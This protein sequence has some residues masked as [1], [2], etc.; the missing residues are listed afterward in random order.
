LPILVIGVGLRAV[1]VAPAD[2][3]DVRTTIAVTLASS[4]TRV[5]PGHHVT[6]TGSVWPAHAGQRVVLEQLGPSG[7]QPIADAN[8]GRTS[9]FSIEHR[10]TTN[11]TYQLRAYLSSD[12]ANAHSYSP[13]LN[14]AVNGIF[15]IQHVVVVMQENR[16]FDSYFGTYPGA[17]G[18]PGLAGNPGSLPCA[19]DPNNGGC[20]QPFHDTN[21]ENYG[22]P[23]GVANAVPDA[24]CSSYAARTNC[25]MDGFVGQAERARRCTPGEASCLPCTTASTTQCIDAMG[26]HDASEIPN[27]WA[28]ANNFV[29]QDHMFEPNDSYSLPAHLY[30]VSEWSAYCTNPQDPF[31]CTN[32]VQNPNPSNGKLHYAWTDITYLLHKFGVSWGYYVFPGTEPDCA[33]PSAVTCAA[34]TQTPQTPGLWNPLPSFTD[35]THDGQLS[36]I[37]S[38]TNFSTAAQNGTLPNVSWVVPSGQVSEH[39]PYL[40]SSGQTYVTGLVNEIMESP[41]WDSTAIFLAWD[42]WSGFYDNVVPP[43]A[44]A[45]GY[46]MRVPAMVISPY[47]IPGYIDHQTLSFD[48]YNKFIEDDFLGGQALDPSTDGRP[49]PRPDVREESPILGNLTSDFNFN[50][51]PLPPLILPVCPTTDLTPPPACT[52]THSEIRE[53]RDASADSRFRRTAGRRSRSPGSRRS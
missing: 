36:N 50:Q 25:K 12:A 23:H 48:A 39:P 8:L 10:F 35:V 4:E 3:V 16:S 9:T 5:V 24:D 27:Y 53:A 40:V 30:M 29:L 1:A 34:V 33:N 41:D 31:S 38:I 18:I 7:W 42:D 51:T 2:K 32:S 43:A 47:A 20:D 52:A 44:D 11:G 14:V 26:Y 49:D 19:P 28:Y 21:D 37:Q 46:G 6:L 22:G 15:N 17:D 13:P 45:N